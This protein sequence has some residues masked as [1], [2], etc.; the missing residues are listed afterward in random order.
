M[1]SPQRWIGH[2]SC[3][4]GCGCNVATWLLVFGLV[5]GSPAAF[6][7]LDDACF[8]SALNRTARVEVDGVWVLPNVPANAGPVRVR[9]TCVEDG[10]LRSGQSD[11][12]TVSSGAVIAVPDID[13][14]SQ[15]PI[16]AR[17]ELRSPVATLTA[18]GQVVS[19]QALASYPAGA[20]ADV[21]PRAAGTD[22]RSSNPAIATV[23]PD[24][25]V[26]AVSS[27]AVLVS[28][29]HEGALG[30]LRLTVVLSGD[31][32]GDGLPDD[33]ELAN[34]LDPNNPVDALDD[35]DGDGLST[36]D[37][38][39]A[40]LDPFDPDSDA[41]GLLDGREVNEVG[42][43]A[44]LV[45]TDGDGLWDGLEVA[46][47]SDPLDPLSF[48][49]A[50]TLASLEVS[51]GLSR[52]LVNLVL[53]EGS[54]QLRVNGRLIDGNSID[55][56]SRRYGTAYASSDLLVANFGAEDGRVYGGQDGVATITAEVAGLSATAQVQVETFA[57]R[58]LSFLRIPGYPKAV[59]VEGSFAFVAAGATGL[60][61]VDVSDLE[62]PVLVGALDTASNANDVLVRSGT[63][64]VADGWG[65]LLVIDVTTPTA[66][67]R[68]G[69]AFTNGRATDLALAGDRV[70]VAD[71]TGLSIVDVSDPAEPQLLGSVETP[72]RTRGV[73]VEGNLAAVADTRSGVHVIDVADPAAP[74]L[75]GTAHTRSNGRS[76]AADVALESGRAWV[77]DGADN[78]TGGLS[79]LS[80]EVP[81][82]PVLVAAS[83]VLGLTSVAL[84]RGFALASDY[85]FANGV[86]VL[87]IR[88]GTPIFRA[89]LDFSGA[90]SFRHDYGNGVAVRDGVVF[91]AASCCGWR[92]NGVTDNGGLHIGRYALF[93][94]EGG[95]P[96]GSA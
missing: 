11:Y 58:A 61:V 65:G 46:T 35:A 90:P 73:A 74:V 33:F 21:T 51:P 13:F 83:P 7:Q 55:L 70:Y 39:T 31:S 54:R 15:V 84:E 76:S 93:A 20:V 32:D 92:D 45:D 28:A 29:A 16:P 38:F 12:V 80:L 9:A 26:T 42:T 22:Y 19:L 91:L 50:A 63:A 14:G 79:V 43:N 89:L 95:E 17:L 18:A 36:I 40:G 85:L 64:Y 47:G 96:P 25:L 60:Q 37:E 24:G 49:L 34:G 72:G 57:P 53:G 23:S 86:P 94:E 52:L 59:A 1:G 87:D 77:A 27:G 71:E 75:L 48:N 67:A 2:K 81:D 30:L 66:P 56:T 82:N 78:S 62:A 88:S 69:Q 8:V 68:L 3:P 6:A 10:V 5:L 4:W 41:D 44:L